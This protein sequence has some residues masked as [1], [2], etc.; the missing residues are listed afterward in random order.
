[1]EAAGRFVGIDLGKRT[2]EMC[3]VDQKGKITRTNGKTD[4]KGL[5]KLCEKLSADDLVAIEACNLAMRIERQIRQTVGCKV[6]VLNPGK[7][8]I[9]YMSTRK[10]D[11]EDSLKLAKL[12]KN[13]D[14]DELPIVTPPTDEEWERRK[15]L[16]E[17]KSLKGL[18]TKEINK[19]HAI[20]EHAGFTQFK[21]KDMCCEKNRNNILPLLKG[22]EKEEAAR[23]IER[24]T[25]LEK[26]IEQLLQKI[27]AEVESDEKVQLA[28]TVPGIGPITALAYVAYMGDLSRFDNPHQVSN[29]IGFVP[30]V[31]NSCTIRHSGRTTKNGNALLR[32]MLV[33][34]A[35]GAVRSKDGG[36]LRDKYKY[37]S[38]T[39]GIGKGKSIVT[40]ARK[41]GELLYMLLKTNTEY[42]PQK[43]ITPE[44]KISKLAEE[45]LAVNM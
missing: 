42:K 36:A 4:F 8:A 41:L 37:M 38:Q 26:Q 7:L 6:F 31:D 17:Y 35:W 22:Y 23:L 12:L 20:F 18:R 10:T 15:L 44:F 19:L 11:K 43:F 27:N 24:L 9:I 14:E 34:A 21:R 3:L 45:T 33:Q 13:H 2:Y 25:L 30:K 29:F 1:M 5:D 39:K 40:T 32:S 16:S 28:M